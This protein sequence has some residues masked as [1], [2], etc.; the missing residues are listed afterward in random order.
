MIL[1]NDEILKY[2]EEVRTQLKSGQAKEHAYR[3]ALK[4]LMEAFENVTAVNDPKRSAHGNPDFV[5][6]NPKNRDI[7][8]GYAETKDIDISLDKT[9]KSEQL[10][11]YAG[12]ENLFLTDYLEFRFFQ[13]GNKYQ[14][15]TIGKVKGNELEVYPDQFERLADELGQ[16]LELPPEKIKSGRRLAEIMGAKARR[17]RD[18]VQAYLDNADDERSQELEKIFNMMKE[19]LVHDLTVEKF[20]DMYA[21]TLVYGLFVARYSDKSPDNFTRIEARDLVPASNPFLREFFDHIVGPRFDKRLGY[22]VDELCEVFSVSDVNA[23]VHKHLRILESTDEK[24]PIIHFYEDFLKEYD[25]EERKKMGAFYTPL[26]V[27]RFIVRQIDE[28]LRSDFGITNG[29]ADTEKKKVTIKSQSQKIKVDMHRVQILDPAVGTATF[30]NEVIKKVYES[31]RGQEGRWQSYV[32]RDLLP[33]LYGFELMMAPYTIAHLKLGMTLQEMGVNNLS[34]RIGVYLTNTLEE[35]IPRQVDLF[36]FGLAE[37]VS[38]EASEAARIK[39]ERPIMVILGNPPYSATSSNRTEYAN[40]L[41]DKYKVEPGGKQKLQERK[42]WLNDDYVKFIAFAEDMIEK[43]GE[44]IIGMIT[45]HGYLDNPTFRGMRWHLAKTFD[46]I[47]VLDLHG[48]SKRNE[49]A[50]D[51]SKDENV[52]DIQQGVSIILASKNNKTKG[53]KLADVYHADLFGKRKEKFSSLEKSFT[54]KKIEMDP[55]MY[56]FVARNTEGQID[57]EK[58]IDLSELFRVFNTGVLT[59]GDDFIVTGTESELKD[60]LQKLISGEYTKNDLDTKFKLGKNYASWIL[61]NQKTIQFDSSKI[62]SMTYRPFDQRFT[63]FDRNLLWRPRENVMKNFLTGNNL[64][65]VVD[66]QAITDNWSHVQIVNDIIDNRVHLSNKGIPVEMPLYIID[67]N[68]KTPNFDN[69]VLSEFTKNLVNP[70]TPEGILDYIYAVLHSPSYREKYKEFLKIDF[71]R[72]PT[73]KNDEEFNKLSKFGK[74]LRE[75][76]LMQ[77]PVLNRFITT[78]PAGGSNEIEKVIY[79]NGK[80][81]INDDQLFG[82]VPEV[83]W[84]FYIGGYQPAQKWLKERK[85]QKLTSEEIEHYQKL[86][87]VLVETDKIMKEIG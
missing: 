48:N 81:K 52:F 53:D 28:I 61:D 77:S 55:R 56:F 85:G 2:I 1:R 29:L 57:Y 71:P 13:N 59:M 9:E 23:L 17:I 66:R 63:Y 68:T 27:V 12:Y 8:L 30:L 49:K 60:R 26:P 76:H 74:E 79:E 18:N 37:I 24:D 33:R 35:G 19:L 62:V 73:P 42:N 45:N 36:S 14:T 21:Q 47:Y 83:A 58:G 22:I 11:R 10:L 7:I 31:F 50:L 4:T 64:G 6:L 43:N 5:F 16:F 75:L 25:P 51:G 41:V 15:I 38:K 86:I 80:V 70:F 46:K 40:A 82:D 54:W 44:G 78:F 87:I 84:N 39:H 72:V 20:A 67:S 3:P 32:E 65:L 69:N 34:Q